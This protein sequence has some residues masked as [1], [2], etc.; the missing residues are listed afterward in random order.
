MD[1][2]ILLY[3]IN[4]FVFMIFPLCRTIF[5]ELFYLFYL[6]RIFY[7]LNFINNYIYMVLIYITVEIVHII[8]IF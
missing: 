1:L 6:E 3:Y 5:D 2:F 4:A 7:M 8:H